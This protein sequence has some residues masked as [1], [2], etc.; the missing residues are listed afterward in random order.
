MYGRTYGGRELHFEASGGLLHW[1]LVLQDDETESY[2]SIMTGDSLAGEYRGTRLEELP[3]GVK[4]QWKDWVAQHPGTDI[5]SVDGVE[6]IDN[7]PYDNYFKSSEGFR[8][9]EADDDRLPTKAAIYAFTLGDRRYAVPFA[10]IEG[11][12]TLTAGEEPVFLYRPPGVEMFYST[13]AFRGKFVKRGGAWH[14]E[15]SGASVDAATG[16]L[17]GPRP[18]ALD[19]FDTF[20]FNWSMTH[21]ETEIL[22]GGD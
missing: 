9:T 4:T 13:L 7:N 6:H 12:A 19:G 1:S 14:H 2:W 3:F 8:G 10:T 11:G 21:P 20:W 16:K 5:L 22:G 15:G 18:R 17:S